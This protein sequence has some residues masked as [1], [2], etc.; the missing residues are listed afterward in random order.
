MKFTRRAT[1]KAIAGLL[2][3]TPVSQA[4]KANGLAPILELLLDGDC[5]LTTDPGHRFLTSTPIPGYGGLVKIERGIYSKNNTG[6][7]FEIYIGRFF[8]NSGTL[9]ID[10]ECLE[11]SR[12]IDD[13]VQGYAKL[14]KSVIF[15]SG[16]FGWKKVTIPIKQWTLNDWE[17]LVF[18]IS[19]VSINN[20]ESFYQDAFDIA[21]LQ[22]DD[23]RTINPNR[24]FINKDHPA[25][26]DANPGTQDLP[27]A[28]LQAG[29]DSALTAGK[30]IYIV[31][32]NTP[33]QEL[34][35]QRS[36]GIGGA[37]INRTS[38]GADFNDFFKIDKLPGEADPVIDNN[39][40]QTSSGHS[41]APLYFREGNSIWVRNLIGQNC[42]TGFITNPARN[43]SKLVLQEITS[44]QHVSG[45]NLGA[46]R[47]DNLSL[48]LIHNCLLGECYDNR[49]TSA[50]N[51]YNDPVLNAGIYNGQT[52]YAWHAGV[53]GF[54]DV[55]CR[56]EYS[57][58]FKCARPSFHKEQDDEL[59]PQSRSVCNNYA[60][61]YTGSASQISNQGA[62]HGAQNSI[63]MFNGVYQGR[64][65]FSTADGQAASLSQADGGFVG[66]NSGYS[67]KALAGIRGVSNVRV[68]D[69][70]IS[71]VNESI[72][73]STLLINGQNINTPNR[74]TSY[75]SI[76]HNIYHN[77]SPPGVWILDRNGPN[78]HIENS[79][80]G[81]QRVYSDHPTQV[82]RYLSENPDIGSNT[83]NPNF[84]D[85]ENGD[86]S[87]PNNAL[88]GYLGD[89]PIGA[90]FDEQTI[91]GRYSS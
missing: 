35:R 68:Q 19:N 60:Y 20:G 10:W 58:I 4:T 54:R 46:I 43:L 29:I 30:N 71:T 81:W 37:T 16:E 48:G 26:S 77:I 51:L 61:E 75:N 32:A 22:I 3:L 63:C 25:A 87:R 15:R 78:Q 38:G 28:S 11:G 41:A 59:V 64:A 70:A 80:A 57:E 53:H 6:G 18:R 45:D 42:L 88:D 23:G 50:Q 52:V 33:Y 74:S 17:H 34:S 8:G 66:H 79:L 86:F 62:R 12:A 89:Y 2:S 36:T 72:R 84:A 90:K 13:F 69:N 31:P 24:I 9:T 85:P 76:K 44:T 14:N 82:T 56:V 5:C 91:I 67:V 7:V 83:N 40:Q 49:P 65:I 39:H 27:Y 47:I 73:D 55:A 1:F 21:Y